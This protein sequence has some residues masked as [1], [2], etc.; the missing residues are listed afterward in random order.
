[1]IKLW[2]A[3]IRWKKNTLKE[4]W[5]FMKQFKFYYELK[6]ATKLIED[7]YNQSYRKNPTSHETLILKGKLETLKEILW[8]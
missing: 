1:M 3:K 4:A 7:K 6:K 2:L 5:G 8:H